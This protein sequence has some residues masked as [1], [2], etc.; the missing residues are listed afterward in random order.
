MD[1]WLSQIYKNKYFKNQVFNHHEDTQTRKQII[2]YIFPKPFFPVLFFTVPLNSVVILHAF[3]PHCLCLIGIHFSQTI[4]AIVLQS[5]FRRY[6]LHED[7]PYRTVGI[8]T[9]LQLSVYPFRSLILYFPYLYIS[10]SG[11]SSSSSNNSLLFF[12]YCELLESFWNFENTLIIVSINR[13]LL[14]EQLIICPMI[15]SR[16]KRLWKHYTISSLIFN[17]L[18]SIALNLVNKPTQFK[19]K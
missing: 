8:F 3:P 14:S 2:T 4:N 6:F 19:Y 9:L 18:C 12:L 10:I 16:S 7:F 17:Q 5:Q 15:W 1:W 11:N 13:R